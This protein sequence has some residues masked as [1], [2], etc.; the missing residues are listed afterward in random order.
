MKNKEKV[1]EYFIDDVKDH[2]MTIL[3]E[4]GVY[5]HVKFSRE[6]SNYFRFDLT[7]IPGYLFFTGDMGS[8]TFSRVNDMFTFFRDDDL[9]INPSYWSEKLQA[10]DKHEG[11]KE[12]S[13]ELA[14]GV[15]EDIVKNYFEDRGITGSYILQQELDEQ[16]YPFIDEEQEFYKAMSEFYSDEA[17]DLFADWWEDTFEEYTFRYLWCCYAIVWGIEQYDK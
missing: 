6:G 5:R 1:K 15:V 8:F 4:D 14:R 17:G 9:K 3:H 2:K 13:P 16:I 10:T 12:Y 7:T 11:Y